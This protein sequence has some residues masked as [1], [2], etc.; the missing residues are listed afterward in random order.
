MC[1]IDRSVITVN[2]CML[3]Q[4]PALLSQLAQCEG[5][6]D[7]EQ[8]YKR[9]TKPLIEILKQEY[10]FWNQ[11]SADRFIFETLLLSSGK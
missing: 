9:H 6:N 7:I 10:Q 11:H 3:F 2:V 5:H 8:L 1:T 4:A